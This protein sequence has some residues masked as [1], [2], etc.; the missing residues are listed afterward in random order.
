ML[1]IEVKK[2]GLPE[3]LLFAT[4]EAALGLKVRNATYRSV[5]EVS[6][7]VASRDL[8]QA[9]DAGFLEAHGERRGR[10]YRGTKR[11]FDIRAL[12]REPKNIRDPFESPSP[13]ELYLPGLQQ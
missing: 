12:T 5:A 6:L 3:R 1:E 2:A 4:A 11:I 8:K 7:Q 10:F 13:D 9:A